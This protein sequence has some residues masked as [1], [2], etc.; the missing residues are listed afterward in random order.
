MKLFDEG[1]RTS[2]DYKDEWRNN[3]FKYQN[4]SS[5]H[6]A[7]K[8][9]N[10]LELW[11]SR[12]PN[13]H[14]KVELRSRLRSNREGY[15]GSLAE[16][17]FHELLLK[18]GHKP[19]CAAAASEPDLLV[20]HEGCNTV[21]E[22]RSIRGIPER[23]VSLANRANELQEWA[24][25]LDLQ[26]CHMTFTLHRQGMP[27]KKRE[28]LGFLEMQIG[29]NSDTEF[30]FLEKGWY[31]HGR[32]WRGRG[33]TLV[34]GS[35]LQGNLSSKQIAAKLSSKRP[36][37][38]DTEHTTYVLAFMYYDSFLDPPTLAGALYGERKLRVDVVK[39]EAQGFV[40]NGPAL[41]FAH[42]HWRN[43]SIS[44]VLSIGGYFPLSKGESVL[45]LFEHPCVGA[46]RADWLLPSLSRTRVSSNNEIVV[47][48]SALDDWLDLPALDSRKPR[49]AKS[50]Q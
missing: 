26:G 38:Y 4:E 46:S 6:N 22:V 40:Y 27:L 31:L 47:Q 43:S 10:T 20:E 28:W 15:Y 13:G 24:K 44:Y 1:R 35:S 37:K 2:P 32:L 12:I 49:T 34:I 18:A 42:D 11:Y 17:M 9:R 33:Q 45:T 7:S 48:P 25:S 3:P 21:V 16:L 19:I 8:L 41:W 39:R 29:G 36:R 23:D 50:G 14:F 30:T 5:G